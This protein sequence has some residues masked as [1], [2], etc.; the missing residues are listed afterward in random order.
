MQKIVSGLIT[1]AALL[2]LAASAAFAQQQRVEY[3]ISF[4]NAAVHE[5][6]V[7]ATFTGVPPQDTPPP[8]TL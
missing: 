6:R 4:P 7:V 8:F 2:T 5:A 3:D 1:S